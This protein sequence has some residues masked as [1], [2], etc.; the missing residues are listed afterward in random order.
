MNYNP[1]LLNGLYG[2]SSSPAE[3]KENPFVDSKPSN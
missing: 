3:P 2:N 1:I